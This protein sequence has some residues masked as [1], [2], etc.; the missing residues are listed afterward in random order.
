MNYL[1]RFS[2]ILKDLDFPSPPIFRFELDFL[3]IQISFRNTRIPVFVLQF[4]DFS[5]IFAK[6][7]IASM[8]RGLDFQ[9]SVAKRL[10]IDCT[11]EIDFLFDLNCNLAEN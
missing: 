9:G 2:T 8:G 3:A 1:T 7:K 5:A 4:I 10:H 6:R 11:M